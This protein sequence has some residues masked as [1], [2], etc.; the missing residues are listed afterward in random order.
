MSPIHMCR[1]AC[2]LLCAFFACLLSAHAAYAAAPSTPALVQ[3]LESFRGRIFYTAERQSDGARQLIRGTAVIG[4]ADWSLDERWGDSHLHL[5]PA[6]SWLQSSAETLHFDDPFAVDELANAWMPMLATIAS[7]RLTAVDPPVWTRDNSTFLFLNSTLDQASGLSDEDAGVAYSFDRWTTVNGLS[8]PQG[9]VRLRGDVAVD[10]VL[11][12]DYTVE[13]ASTS[14]SAV[15][16]GAPAAAPAVTPKPDRLA[17]AARFSWRS[18]ATLFGALFTGLA[19]LLWWR[20][21]VLTERWC[22]WLAH[23]ERSWRHQAEPSFVSADGVLWWAGGRYRVG[24][25]FYNRR[26][27]V[28][29]SPLFIRV[30]APEVGR[31]LVIPRQFSLKRTSGAVPGARGFS[32]VES[33]VATAA[34]ATVAI[35]VVL[36]TLIVLSRADAMALARQRALQLASNA[37]VDE[38]AALSYGTIV[39]APP[40]HSTTLDGLTATTTVEPAAM[41]NGWLITVLVRSSSGATLARLATIVGPPVPAPASSPGPSGS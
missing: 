11:V 12:S 36:P 1:R 2:S 29:S 4:S 20:R 33:L 39:A 10:S 35:A 31:T 37:L 34:F 13:W 19:L 17:D 26:T 9:V 23:D 3:T 5:A 30:S 18:F 41:Q 27:V 24:A 40:E 16:A 7:G 8:L 28:Q 22:A 6:D 32:L 15:A 14:S 38:E 21:D 25:A